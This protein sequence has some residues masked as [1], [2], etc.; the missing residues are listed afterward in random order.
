MAHI[1]RA[2]F[3]GDRS[4]FELAFEALSKRAAPLLLAQA[5]RFGLAHDEHCDSAQ[6][7]L[8]RVLEAIRDDKADF[9]ESN[10]A[11]FALWAEISLYRK[12]KLRVPATNSDSRMDKKADSLASLPSRMPSPEELALFKH[13]LDSLPPKQRRAFIQYY[14][15]ELTQQ[16]IAE[17]HG[18]TV[19]TVYNW[20]K[21][22]GA[23]MGLYGG[24][25]YL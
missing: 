10:F 1:S 4:A 23:V 15:L 22:A 5:R 17:R 7:V 19:C 16:E 11:V 13:G 18:V 14:L 21:V 12:R 24:D 6:D 25:D 2:F 9:A 8:V 20:L 3:A